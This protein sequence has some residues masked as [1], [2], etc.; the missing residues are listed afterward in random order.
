MKGVVWCTTAIDVPAG[1]NATLKLLL[2]GSVAGL[3]YLVPKPVLTFHG[4]AETKGE[5]VCAKAI[6]VPAGLNA[7]PLPLPVGS[8]AG[9]VYLAPKPAPPLHGYA[10]M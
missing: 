3:V 7:T 8:V 9:S 4:Y 2:A 1:L 10:E 6:E 5:V